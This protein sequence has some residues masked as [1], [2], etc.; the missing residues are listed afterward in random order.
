[1]GD[2]PR[3]LPW[4]ANRP[5]D[6]RSRCTWAI[7]FGFGASRQAVTE[8]E[9]APVVDRENENFR[10]TLKARTLELRVPIQIV[11]PTTYDNDA[12]VKRKLAELS[13]RKVQDE[14]TRAWNFFAL[15]YK[16]G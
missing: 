11:W 1:M 2:R 13:K 8:V 10:G 5:L 14:A 15:Y 7:R 3:A 12:V 6:S 4:K 9:D 16:A